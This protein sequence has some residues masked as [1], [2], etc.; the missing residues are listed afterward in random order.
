MAFSVYASV[1]VC[2]CVYIY[3]QHFNVHRRHYTT[4]TFWQVNQTLCTDRVANVR[5]NRKT[6]VFFTGIYEKHNLCMKFKLNEW[7]N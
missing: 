3:R 1:C 6:L 5:L 4:T 7:N 2:M